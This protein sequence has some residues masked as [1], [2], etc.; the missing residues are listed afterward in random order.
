MAMRDLTGQRFGRLLAL[1]NSGQQAKDGSYLWLCRCDCG[2]ETI[3]NGSQM[4]SGRIRS[5]GCLVGEAARARSQ[6]RKRP[7]VPCSVAGCAD[8]TEKGGHGLCGKHAQRMRRYGSVDHVTSE[9]TRR[10]NNR[11]SQLR[12]IETVKPGTYRKLFGRHEHRVIAERIAG[13]K[14]RRDEHVHH[15]DGNKQNNDP[16]NLAVMSA[17]DHAALHH[18]RAK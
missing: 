1:A 10:A 17:A 18:G 7:P 14:L 15:I 6:A 11:A 2:S 8:T 9:E 13:R 12:G 16:S 4:V 3:R 5:C